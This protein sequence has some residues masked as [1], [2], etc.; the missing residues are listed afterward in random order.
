[1]RLIDL[2]SF[3]NSFQATSFKNAVLLRF[4]VLLI[5]NLEDE[6]GSEKGLP[7]MK[8]VK[9]AFNTVKHDSGLCRFLS[10]GFGQWGYTEDFESADYESMPSAFLAQ[11]LRHSFRSWAHTS[12]SDCDLE[13]RQNWCAYHD[14]VD[15]EA[16]SV[17]R[18]LS[19][20]LESD[21]EDEDPYEPRAARKTMPGMTSRRPSLQ[22]AARRAPRKALA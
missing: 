5:S 20:N 8:V 15:N 22:R 6:D 13:L 1:M 19:L 14:H 10:G 18:K 7:S 4:Q 2:Y 21:S 16:R 9:H 17:C 11:V 12:G 3:A